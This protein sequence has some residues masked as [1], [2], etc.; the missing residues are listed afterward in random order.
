MPI[1]VYQEIL[2]DGSDGRRFEVQQS[3]SEPALTEDPESGRAVRRVYQ[4]PNLSTRYGPG[5]TARKTDKENLEKHGF[6]R[7]E[8]DKLTGRYH[9]T[10]GVDGRAP[11]VLDPRSGG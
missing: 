7:Y 6:T 4:P 8:R 11:N 3:M 1:Y 9:K 2:D 5:S 10:A